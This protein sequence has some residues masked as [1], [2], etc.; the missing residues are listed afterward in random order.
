M[1]EEPQYILQC[2]KCSTEF[3]ISFVSG[4]IDYYLDS[5]VEL[6]PGEEIGLGGLKTTGVADYRH[7]NYMFNTQATRY[8]PPEMMR[9]LSS[10]N[11]SEVEKLVDKK[12]E[13]ALQRDLNERGIPQYKTNTESNEKNTD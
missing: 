6:A 10:I 1:S 4:E 13:A 3:G 7:A 9:P 12:I 5:E 8:Q 2:P 11:T